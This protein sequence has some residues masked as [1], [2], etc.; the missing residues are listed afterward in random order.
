MD[1]KVQRSLFSF[2]SN[3]GL[4]SIRSGR[5]HE[6]EAGVSLVGSQDLGRWLL[7]EHAPPSPP[8]CCQQQIAAATRSQHGTSWS[9]DYRRGRQPEPTQI[10][11]A[12]YEI[13]RC[14]TTYI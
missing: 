10:L 6:T 12:I 13:I 9:Y 11:R 1:S 7:R 3:L 5:C 2:F 8:S 4:T 14:N